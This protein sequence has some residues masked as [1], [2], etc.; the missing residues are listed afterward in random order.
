M[1]GT[2]I[3]VRTRAPFLIFMTVYLLLW[4]LIWFILLIVIHSEPQATPD[5]DFTVQITLAEMTLQL[6]MYVGLLCLAALA[7]AWYA[8]LQRTKAARSAAAMC[9]TICKSAWLYTLW[10]SIST[11][12]K[13]YNDLNWFCGGGGVFPSITGSKSDWC[14]TARTVAVVNVLIGAGL[15]ALWVWTIVNRFAR[16]TPEVPISTVGAILPAHHRRASNASNAAHNLDISWRTVLTHPEDLEQSFIAAAYPHLYGQGR[17]RMNTLSR[18]GTTLLVFI[19][20]G[21]LLLT[22]PSIAFSK[23]QGLN[24]WS[25]SSYTQPSSQDG[26]Y[27]GWGEPVIAYNWY[28]LIVTL[29]A[30]VTATSTADG[31]THRGYAALACVLAALSGSQWLSFFVYS[32]RRAHTDAQDVVTTSILDSAHAEYAEIGGAGIIL[33]SQLCIAI[34][35]FIRYHSY[36][37]I[38]PEHQRL[39]NHPAHVSSPAVIAVEVDRAVHPKI[40]NQTLPADAAE[41]DMQDRMYVPGPYRDEATTNTPSYNLPVLTGVGWPLKALLACEAVL[42]FCWWVTQIVASSEE[43]VFDVQYE[44]Q[45]FVFNERMFILCS[46]LGAAALLT[47]VYAE[48][49]RQLPTA[50]AHLFVVTATLAG[51]FLLVWPFAFQ[52]IASSGYLQQAACQDE[53]FCRLTKTAAVFALMQGFLLFFAL[54][55]AVGR[56]VRA[57]RG[58]RAV[59]TSTVGLAAASRASALQRLL[60]RLTV[61]L[62]WA[63][64]SLVWVWAL[65]TVATTVRS[66]WVGFFQQWQSVETPQ[67][68]VD[69]N[70]GNSWTEGYWASVSFLLTV[71]VVVVGWLVSQATS[72]YEWQSR[73]VRVAT[74]SACILLATSTFPMLIFACRFAETLSLNGDQN[75]FVA[76]FILLPFVALALLVCQLLRCLEPLYFQKGQAEVLKDTGH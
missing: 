76:V 19:S 32:A 41:Q 6:Y 5:N 44:A 7:G 65:A 16:I 17:L 46:V 53:S 33:I 64:L 31:R 59:A 28:W 2:I 8:D 1:V 40:L 29:L 67:S 51:F 50:L 38:L 34:T 52:S 26:E 4:L 60:V 72:A 14:Y 56:T 61:A 47:S 70:E 18:V 58:E 66:N 10:Y 45:A 30:S 21:G 11:F 27:V 48:R 13:G 20:I 22:Y 37:R 23:N 43:A 3:P 74:V 62:V 36:I 75:T 71:E 68:V 9:G 24:S 63:L 55:L 73:P 15:I 35:L 12:Y 54:L 69:G 49:L 25:T 39:F 57:V 42:L